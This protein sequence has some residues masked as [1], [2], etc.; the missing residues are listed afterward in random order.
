[1]NDLTVVTQQYPGRTMITVRGEIDLQTCPQLARAAAAVPLGGTWLY[2]DVSGVP[3]MDSSGLNLLVALRR[4]LHTAGGR[5][6][7]TGLQPQPKRLLQITGAYALF[8]VDTAV[9]GS[10]EALTASPPAQRNNCRSTIAKT[11]Y[12]PNGIR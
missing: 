12:P 7:V 5:L 4:R 10:N 9:D 6:A 3:F 2:L 11:C 8:V 1:V